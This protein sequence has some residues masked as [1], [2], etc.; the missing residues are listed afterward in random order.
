MARNLSPFAI[1]Y[2][3]DGTL[4]SGNMQEYDFVPK[5]GMTSKHFWQEVNALTKK[6][7]ADNILIYMMHML[8]KAQAAQVPGPWPKQKRARSRL[9][10]QRHDHRRIWDSDS[11]AHPAHRGPFSL[12]SLSL[13]H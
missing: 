10:D 9:H 11:C 5:I 13:A 7:N 1:A 3:F 4:A 2:D 8:D 12:A 6:H